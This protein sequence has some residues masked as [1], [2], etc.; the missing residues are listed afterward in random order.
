MSE[1]IV[2]K[3]AKGNVNKAIIKGAVA[4]YCKVQKPS[5]IYEQRMMQNPTKTEYSVDLL[6]DED[7]ADQWDEMFTKQPSKKMTA[8]KFKEK[9]K[10][11]DES[12]LPDPKA[13]KFFLIKVKQAAQK[14]DGSDIHPK[15]RPRVA[16]VVDGKPVDI[17]FKELVGNG[18]QVDVLMRANENDFGCFAYLGTVKV[19]KLISYSVDNTDEDEEEFLGGSMEL[20]E[21]PENNGVDTSQDHS[22]ESG[23]EMPDFADDDSDEDEY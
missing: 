13:K 1:L 21:V 6:V 14:K 16:Q 23:E 3:D 2:K 20:D 19:N 11:E 18:S 7:T 12:V 15:M 22:E 5:P 4:F 8:A 17:T 10:I 9:F